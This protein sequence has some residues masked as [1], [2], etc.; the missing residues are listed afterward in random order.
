MTLSRQV[1]TMLRTYQ[2][3]KKM[4]QL[5]KITRLRKSRNL[6]TL[7]KMPRYQTAW[8]KKVSLSDTPARKL[9]GGV[10]D[11]TPLFL[12]KIR[13]Y[14]VLRIYCTN[15]FIRWIC[16]FTNSY[17]SFAISIINNL[18]RCIVADNNRCSISTICLCL[19]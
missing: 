12:L 19:R 3:E 7:T 13:V 4:K 15:S 17:W 14:I 9:I 2:R 6:T 8:W 11:C 5:K 1:A 16:I 10:Y 18:C